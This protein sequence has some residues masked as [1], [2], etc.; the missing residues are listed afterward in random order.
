LVGTFRILFPNEFTFEGNRAIVFS[1]S[2]I[3]QTDSL[4]LCIT[5]ALTYH[6]NKGKSGAM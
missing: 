1:E 5:A 2:D 3:V 6:L 4:S